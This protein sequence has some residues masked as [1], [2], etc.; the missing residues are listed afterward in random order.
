M[1][2]AFLNFRGTPRISAM[3]R[4]VCAD[5]AT[6]AWCA[7]PIELGH[8][9]WTLSPLVLGPDRVPVVSD[10]AVAGR[11]PELAVLSAMAHGGDPDRTDVLRALVSALAAVDQERAT[12]YSNV[13]LAA[14]PAAAHHYLEH[15]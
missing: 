3:R 15:S 1:N 2:M 5:N 7:V 4:C 8:P 6:A 12:L 9:G 14:L 11:A 10:A 13:V